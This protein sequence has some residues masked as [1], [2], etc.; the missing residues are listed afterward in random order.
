VYHIGRGN[1]SSGRG[2]SYLI[3]LSI[4]EGKES[5]GRKEGKEAKLIPLPV[6]SGTYHHSIQREE[7]KLGKRIALYSLLLDYT[8]PY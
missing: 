2:V 5:K 6:K 4:Y 1:F 3:Y 7:E 8:I